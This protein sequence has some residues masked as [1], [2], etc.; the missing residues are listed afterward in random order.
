MTDAER[1]EIE[2]I[3]AF[4]LTIYAK[5]ND[6]ELAELTPAELNKLRDEFDE[7]CRQHNELLED[8]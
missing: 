1:M 2:E 6:V 3:L 5:A 8:E 7:F 4:G